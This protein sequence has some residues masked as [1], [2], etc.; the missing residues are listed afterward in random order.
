MMTVTHK[1]IVLSTIS[2]LPETG[3]TLGHYS[4]EC[5]RW[6]E[7]IP[8]EWLDVGK[9]DVDY[10]EQGFKCK[11]CRGRAD[12]QVRPSPTG[13]STESAYTGV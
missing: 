5:D 10:V 8:Q 4:L 3:M 1:L 12:K 2:D 11:E 6:G 13:L 7:I 9:P